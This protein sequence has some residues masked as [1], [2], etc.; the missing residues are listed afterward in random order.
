MTS[1]LALLMLGCVAPE[2]VTH[3]TL[4]RSWRGTAAQLQG[5]ANAHVGQ[6]PGPLPVHPRLPGG[7]EHVLPSE[8]VLPTSPWRAQHG[9]AQQAH[10]SGA[11]RTNFKVEA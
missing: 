10:L 5:T 7:V 11:T 9:G 3:H 6:L 2:Q 8:C 1:L 4:R